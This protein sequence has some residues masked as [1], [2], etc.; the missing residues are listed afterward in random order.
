MAPSVSPP[1]NQKKGGFMSKM[2]YGIFPLTDKGLL[3]RGR[4]PFHRGVQCG[5]GC[6]SLY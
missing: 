5:V 3:S 2:T 4:P 1:F 6:S